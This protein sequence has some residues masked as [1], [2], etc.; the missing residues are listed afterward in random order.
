MKALHIRWTD[1]VKSWVDEAS[2]GSFR[3]R[4]GMRLP[5]TPTSDTTALFRG[6]GVMVPAIWGRLIDLENFMMIERGRVQPYFRS[7]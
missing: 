2:L 6:H 1:V 5:S 3:L 4:C 7:A